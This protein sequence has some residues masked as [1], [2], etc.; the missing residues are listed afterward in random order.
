MPLFELKIDA[1]GGHFGEAEHQERAVIRQ[2]VETV[3]QSLGDG[4]STG[5]DVTL[6]GHKKIGSWTYSPVAER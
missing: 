2:A 1:P 5:G 6:S 3:L 4:K